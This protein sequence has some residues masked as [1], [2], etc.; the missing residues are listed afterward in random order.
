LPAF[1]KVTGD[2]TS[3]VAVQLQAARIFGDRFALRHGACSPEGG[4]TEETKEQ[5]DEDLVRWAKELGVS[6][7]ELLSTLNY[8]GPT[9][10]DLTL[11]SDARRA[12][13]TSM[14]S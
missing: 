5:R 8:A 3:P 9:F 12:G 11:S 1:E 2:G 4:M 13:S 14:P 7:E 6:Y 10:K